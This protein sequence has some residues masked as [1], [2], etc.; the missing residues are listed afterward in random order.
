MNP[1]C[2]S[3]L[4]RSGAP[5]GKEELW[6]TAERI[7]NVRTTQPSFSGKRR[8]GGGRL[9]TEGSCS[10]IFAFSLALISALATYRPRV[11]RRARQFD[12][13]GREQR[14]ARRLR[15]RGGGEVPLL[16]PVPTG[17]NDV[18]LCQGSIFS[19]SNVHCQWLQK[20]ISQLLQ[21]PVSRP[22]SGE[23]QVYF[24]CYFFIFPDIASLALTAP[25]QI[26]EGPGFGLQQ[27]YFCLFSAF[28]FRCFG[29]RSGWADNAPAAAGRAEPPAPCGTR[30]GAESGAQHGAARGIPLAMA[31]RGSR[32]PAATV[33][34]RT[35]EGHAGRGSAAG[36]WTM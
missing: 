28:A 11:L 18:G 12:A 10:S 19:A 23:K 6:I 13:S 29:P 7:F 26:P 33:G 17:V 9:G 21:C 14:L 3:G 27:R 4:E 16:S 1:G 36:S 8:S 35:S 24:Y 15:A 20:G 30:A 5:G 22:A 34:P 2:A 32:S 25:R 31:A